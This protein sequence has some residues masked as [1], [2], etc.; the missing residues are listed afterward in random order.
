MAATVVSRTKYSEGNIL[1]QD[2]AL[3]GLT[4]NQLET[5]T[6]TG[7]DDLAPVSVDFYL[8]TKPTDGSLLQFV[9]ESSAATSETVSVRFMTT[10]GGSL[11]GALGTLRLK[12]K[13]VA[14]QARQSIAQDNNT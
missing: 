7:Y 13:G 4:A 12:W 6:H 5:I 3:S 11:T 2:I 1:V 9:W 8:T 14:P 10:A